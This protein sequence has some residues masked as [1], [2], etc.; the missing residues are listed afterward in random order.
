MNLNLI[1]SILEGWGIIL[2]K[3]TKFNDIFQFLQ[4]GEKDNI[5]PKTY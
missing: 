5:L 1:P 4:L 3:T 2:Q